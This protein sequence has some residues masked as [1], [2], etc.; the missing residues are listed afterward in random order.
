[1]K[2]GNQEKADHIDSKYDNQFKVRAI[3]DYE[4]NAGMS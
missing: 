3:P 4:K 2:I 1:M